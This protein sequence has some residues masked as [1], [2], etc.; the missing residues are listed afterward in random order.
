[1]GV[2]IGLSVYRFVGRLSICRFVGRSVCPFARLPIRL[3]I[4]RPSV[5][6]LLLALCFGFVLST[7]ASAAG[8][9]VRDGQLPILPTH[10]SRP[11]VSRAARG[12]HHRALLHADAIPGLEG[13]AGLH[14]RRCAAAV[15]CSPVL[16]CA[17]VSAFC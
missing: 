6:V 16:T 17:G 8:T 2:H 15:L 14:D 9:G 3:R 12:G 4:V 13:R 5:D 11:T 1:M 10:A 7:V